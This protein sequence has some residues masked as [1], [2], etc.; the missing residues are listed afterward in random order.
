MIKICTISLQVLSLFSKIT[1]YNQ[2]K[3]TRICIQ[4]KNKVETQW[5]NN[6]LK[7][8]YKIEIKSYLQLKHCTTTNQ[9]F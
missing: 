4:Q 1:K 6:L 8:I 3:L 7:R 5:H 2:P 9:V